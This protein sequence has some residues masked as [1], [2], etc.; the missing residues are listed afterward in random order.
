MPPL[1][2]RLLVDSWLTLLPC[3][4]VQS[5]LA[6]V[7]AAVLCGGIVGGDRERREKPAG[8]RTLILVCIG[9]ALFTMA[10]F[11][12]TT[13]T[14]DSGRVAAQIVTGIGFLGAGV[15]MHGRGSTITG[16]TTAATIWVT[17]AI[18]MMAAAG[19][20]GGAIGS[21]ILVRTVLFSVEKIEI[22]RLGGF[23]AMEVLV[24]FLPDG[25]KTRV[26]IERELAD[27]RAG[28]VIATWS[29]TGGESE[30][31]TLQMHL[32][33]LHLRELLAELAGIPQVVRIEQA[34]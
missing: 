1:Y 9:S 26:L 30:R 7:L 13:T 2:E 11:A 19:Y 4:A 24:D 3:A 15:I 32:P 27:Y 25:G 17:A 22:H 29:A 20:V 8:L 12:F 31:L 18:G 34:A 10:G 5:H 6:V 23:T 33:R 28:T 21:A 14:G 16:T